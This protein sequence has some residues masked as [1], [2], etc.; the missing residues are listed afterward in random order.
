LYEYEVIQQKYAPIAQLTARL[1]PLSLGIALERTALEFWRRLEE[2]TGPRR[3]QRSDPE[4]SLDGTIT[5]QP[6]PVGTDR[7][8]PPE[9][10]A[11]R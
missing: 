7:M 1:V 9:R 10:T 6:M 8:A 4:L 3:E 2:E 5:P 11:A